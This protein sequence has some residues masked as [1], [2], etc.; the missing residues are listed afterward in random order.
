[1][2]NRRQFLRAGAAATAALAWPFRAF[3]F[4]QSP[5]NIRKFAVQLPGLVPDN[6]SPGIPVLTPRQEMING[7]MTDI[8]DIVAG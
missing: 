6:G 8:Y 2:I 4:S 1:M 5:L 7:V 3:P